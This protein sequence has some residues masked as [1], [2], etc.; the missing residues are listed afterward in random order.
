MRTRVQLG[1]LAA[2]AAT[3]IVTAIAAAVPAQ[4]ASGGSLDPTWGTGGVVTV[5]AGFSP[6][7][8][9][10][11]PN[12]TILDVGGET[13][14]TTGDAE[15]AIL[16]YNENGTVDT[17]FGTDGLAVASF[18][19]VSVGTSSVFVQ[20]DGNIVVAGITEEGDPEVAIAEFNAN[21]TLDTSFGNGGEVTTLFPSGNPDYP[22]TDSVNAVLVDAD[23]NILVGGGLVTCSNPKNSACLSE[24]ALARFTPDGALDTSF[25][26]GGSVVQK[27]GSDSN[28][29]IALGEDSAG[30]IFV[31]YNN[32]SDTIGDSQ[33]TVGE[34]SPAGVPDSTVTF[35]PSASIVISSETS[36]ADGFQP[37]GT[38]PV[39]QMVQIDVGSKQTYDVQVLLDSLPSGTPSAS[40]D[41]PPFAYVSGDAANTIQG[42][43]PIAEPDGDV[44]LDGWSCEIYKH[45]GCQDGAPYLAQLTPTGSLDSTFG[46]G[47]ITAIPISSSGS[48]VVL[49][50]S[51]QPDG[52]ILVPIENFSNATDNADSP[53]ITTITIDRFLG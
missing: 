34:Y 36:S 35:P 8:M 15:F 7:A 42:S 45:G 29:V 32:V 28:S 38:Y 49:S 11:Q 44:V 22:G 23:G 13:N 33:P 10:T 14:A 18:P 16:S 27:A 37:N 52:D 3:L 4:A 17:S 9:L 24:Y 48:T 53:T 2:G 47:G 20:P 50:P 41:N 25:G 6:G 51:V 1:A 12:G 19:G 46:T 31:Q 39:G 43:S 40:F 26:N 5:P 21:G 30:D